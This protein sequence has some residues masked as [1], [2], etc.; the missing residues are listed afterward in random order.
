MEY[1]RPTDIP[2]STESMGKAAAGGRLL[3]TCLRKCDA[4]RRAHSS[5]I[6]AEALQ[7]IGL[8]LG[9]EAEVCRRTL[10]DRHTVQQQRT[11][12]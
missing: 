5:P 11:R 1:C 8:P 9:M 4:L 6:P 3:D 2:T 12:L 7:R 10:D